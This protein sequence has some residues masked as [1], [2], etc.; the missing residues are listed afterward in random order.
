[1]CDFILRIRT[2]FRETIS[3]FRP[4][5]QNLYPMP[6]CTYTGFSVEKQ[7][8]LLGRRAN[9]RNVSYTPNP[10]GDKHTIS[11]F[12]QTCIQLTRQPRK[13]P[14]FFVKISLTVLY[15][16]Q[17][18]NKM[19]SVKTR[20][21]QRLVICGLGALLLLQNKAIRKRRWW[22]RPWATEL[23]SRDKINGGYDLF[24]GKPNN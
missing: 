11:T 17:A 16:C 8:S 12:D 19:A 4:K 5:C 24:L 2:V 21:K 22:V 1:M 10:T 14:D 13:K 18:K 7:Y 3:N 15:L 9:A 6:Y 20:K 23:E